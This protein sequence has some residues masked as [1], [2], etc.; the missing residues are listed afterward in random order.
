MNDTT[1]RVALLNL[2]IDWNS[3]IAEDAER[4]KWAAAKSNEERLMLAG[5]LISCDDAHDNA[6]RHMGITERAGWAGV[7]FKLME[8]ALDYCNAA[9]AVVGELN[10]T[11]H[12]GETNEEFAARFDEAV[13]ALPA[14]FAKGAKRPCKHQHTKSARGWISYNRNNYICCRCGAKLDLPERSTPTA[15][16]RD[17]LSLAVFLSN[18][19]A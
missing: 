12:L 8:Q 6:M 16:A 1:S 2:L 5:V 14:T 7:S 3:A 15:S 9:D 19:P 11:A 4:T 18:N 13:A 17:A 10:Y